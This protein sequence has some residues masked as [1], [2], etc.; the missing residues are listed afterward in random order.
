[1]SWLRNFPAFLSYA[2]IATMSF[3]V[4]RLTGNVPVDHAF[5]EFIIELLKVDPVG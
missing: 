4:G 3:A 5:T 2:V 1:M